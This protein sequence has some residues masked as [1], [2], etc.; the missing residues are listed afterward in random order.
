M[1][2][3][4]LSQSLWATTAIPSR[5][6]PALATRRRADVAI[7]GAGFTGLSA[8]LHL[9]EAGADVVVLEAGEPGIGASGRNGGQVI[10]GL[11]HDPD[12]L[13]VLFGPALGE[14]WIELSGGAADLVFNLIANHR[15]DCQ[16]VQAGWIQGGRSTEALPAMRRRATL[17]RERGVAAEWYDAERMA[18][19]TGTERY[20]GGWVDPRAGAIQPLSYARGLA[21]AAARLGAAIHGSSAVTGL[22][23]QGA[24]WRLSTA[25]GEVEAEQVILATNGYTDGLWPGLKQTVVPVYSIQVATAPLGENVRKSILPGGQVLSDTGRLTWYFRLDHTGR[26]I[27]GSGG[28]TSPGALPK[29]YGGLAERAR[30]LFPQIGEPNFEYRWGGRVAL[31]ADHLPHLHQLAPGLWAGLG[32]N[33]RGV[34]MATA[35]GKLLAAQVRGDAVPDLTLPLRPIPFHGLR[36]QGV[37]IAR[38]WY[39]WRDRMEA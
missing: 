11:K 4:P 24:G 14:A 8:A 21:G 38:T 26:L 34:A 2:P 28:A 31:T 29:M 19:V 32:Y 17:W 5:D 25:D 13:R 10:P 7:V 12:Q 39:A 9:A 6:W 1:E 27:F 23:R 35:M 16:P 15:I 22:S 20:A 33:G 36:N 37:A 18:E 30:R 3:V